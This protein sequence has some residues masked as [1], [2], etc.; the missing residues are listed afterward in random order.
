MYAN[1]IQE[2]HDHGASFRVSHKLQAIQE[3]ARGD[4]NSSR[5]A[6]GFSIIFALTALLVL[7]S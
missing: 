1:T 7:L 4:V 3:A 6:I 2:S 5:Y